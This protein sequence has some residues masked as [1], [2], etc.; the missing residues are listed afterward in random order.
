MCYKARCLVVAAC[1]QRSHSVSLEQPKMLRLNVVLRR[2]DDCWVA[3]CPEL[4]T[5]AADPDLETAWEDIVRICRAHLVYGLKIGMA[6]ADLI[7]PV[8]ADIS[9][10]I[11]QLDTDGFLRLHFNRAVDHTEIKMYRMVA[12]AA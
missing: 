7:K 12:V 2:E 9:E 8:P 4:G 3:R 11:S 5:L 6:L 1:P 10:L